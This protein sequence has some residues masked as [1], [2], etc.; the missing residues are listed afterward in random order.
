MLAVDEI[1]ETAL[2]TW[3]RGIFSARLDHDPIP[4]SD[5]ETSISLGDTPSDAFVVRTAEGDLLL[6]ANVWQYI[7]AYDRVGY[8]WMLREA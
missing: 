5:F 1:D 8:F 6:F 4:L 2:E 3:G 7:G